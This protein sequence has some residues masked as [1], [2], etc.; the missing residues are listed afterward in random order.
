[1]RMISLLRN[2]GLSKSISEKKKKKHFNLKC[3][4]LDKKRK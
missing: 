4:E 1:M 2:Q 3:E